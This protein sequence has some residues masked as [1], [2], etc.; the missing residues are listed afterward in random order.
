MSC[1]FTRILECNNLLSNAYHPCVVA[2]I[3]VYFWFQSVFDIKFIPKNIYIWK[4]ILSGENYLFGGY[5][6]STVIMAA[7]KQGSS[8]HQAFII[9]NLN[10]I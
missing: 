2:P 1:S 9:V 6:K 8:T 4:F 10:T 5:S 7:K 3:A